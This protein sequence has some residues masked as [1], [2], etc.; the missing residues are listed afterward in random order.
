M[1]EFQ[2]PANLNAI[3]CSIARKIKEQR[4]KHK[5]N[6]EEF[7]NKTRP[8]LAV[9]TTTDSGLPS[10]PV[11]ACHYEPF[12]RPGEE[13]LL[14]HQQPNNELATNALLELTGGAGTPSSSASLDTLDEKVIRQKIQALQQEK[15]E[16]FQLMRNLLANPATPSPPPPA[17]AAAAANTAAAVTV[18]ATAAPGPTPTPPSPSVQ[19]P[20]QEQTQAQLPTPAASPPSVKQDVQ[21]EPP[22]SRERLRS[23]SNGRTRT[24]PPPLQFSSPSSCF[25]PT[26]PSHLSRPPPLSS[27]HHH[28]FPPQRYAPYRRISPPPS[29]RYYGRGY[30]GSRLYNNTPLSAPPFPPSSSPSSMP[31]AHR[32]MPPPYGSLRAQSPPLRS[33]SFR[34][35]RPLADRHIPRY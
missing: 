7:K 19:K 18:T 2:P 26:R 29:S 25:S 9:T 4:E 35:P 6:E 3:R 32:R 28:R 24:P 21:A 34:A 14:P 11:E 17:A 1:Y 23:C 31:Y 27:D 20:T 5:K 22:K 10:P 13:E 33:T 15:H 16:L 12:K 30:G 8:T